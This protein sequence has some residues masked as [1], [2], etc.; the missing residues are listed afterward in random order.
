MS[1]MAWIIPTMGLFWV[2]QRMPTRIEKSF[3]PSPFGSSV[4]QAAEIFIL[5]AV[6]V[7]GFETIKIKFLIVHEMQVLV[8]PA[9]YFICHLRKRPE[10][11]FIIPSVITLFLLRAE[12]DQAGLIAG[13]C[14]LTLGIFL[15]QLFLEGIIFRLQFSP[16]P[17]PLRGLPIYLIAAGL[18]SLAFMGFLAS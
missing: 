13:L 7:L 5:S 1:G 10:F 9:L 18:L 16:V 15:F 4:A 3:K 8:V 2:L 17:S 12:S 6:F 11:Y 14:I